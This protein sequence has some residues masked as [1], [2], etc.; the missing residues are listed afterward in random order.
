MK[1][2][3]GMEDWDFLMKLADNNIWGYTIKEIQF[4]YRIHKEV[5]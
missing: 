3:K 5:R 1:I 2:K 4:W